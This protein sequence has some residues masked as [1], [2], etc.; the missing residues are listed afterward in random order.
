MS[1]TPPPKEPRI[2]LD[3][4]L[5]V[6]SRARVSV[7]DRG[8]QY[9]DGLI[10]T[11]RLADGRPV[12]WAAHLTRLQAS[13]AALGIPLPQ[14]NWAADLTRLV[15]AN[16][17]QT[18]EGWARLSVTRGVSQRGLLPPP[19]A[20]PTWVLAAGRLDP[21]IAKARADGVAV[22]SL[23]FGRPEVLGEH[24]HAFYLPAILGKRVAA[25]RGAFDGL[26]V[27]PSGLV[28]GGTSSNLFIWIGNDLLTPTGPGVLP[29][30]TRARV[31]EAAR[32]LGWRVRHRRLPRTR[33][34][35]VDEAFLTNSLFE[36]VP[37]VAI[38]GRRL[39]D[40]PGKRTSALL[41]KVLADHARSSTTPP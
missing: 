36:V 4:R 32:S 29:G 13:A 38:D 26:M 6:A 19:E 12:A 41:R 20:V 31:E 33:L 14:R 1:P 37:I 10:E 3:G 35:A 40:G 24:K 16:D 8:F 2:W 18:G 21:S 23:D 27:S 7:F 5:V 17:L 11:I 15:R 28:Q 22:V 39:G 34:V 25:E 30:I 9:G